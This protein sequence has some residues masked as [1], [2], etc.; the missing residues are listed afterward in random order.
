MD[1]AVYLE[2]LL[3]KRVEFITNGSLSPYIQPYVEKEVKRYEG[4]SVKVSLEE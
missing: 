1:L 3:G 4:E 2:D